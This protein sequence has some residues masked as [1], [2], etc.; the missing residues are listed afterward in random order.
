MCQHPFKEPFNDTDATAILGH[1]LLWRVGIAHG[2]VSF[3]NIML[4]IDRKRAILIDFDLAAVMKPGATSPSQSGFERT[5]TMPFMAIDVLTSWDGPG[6]LRVYPHDLEAIIWCIVWYFHERYD[7]A[8]GSMEEV[9]SKK[10][11]WVRRVLP[12]WGVGPLPRGIRAGI[13][14]R[15]L[16]SIRRI[17]FKW[18]NLLNDQ[19]GGC[20]EVDDK[21][22]NELFETGE[23][24]IDSTYMNVIFKWLPHGKDLYA[25]DWKTFAVP[26]DSI[27]K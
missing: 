20:L 6:P 21:V 22:T 14:G 13:E 4:S 2:D 5:G 3:F 18:Q 10:H 15:H 27:P 11:Q 19:C 1:K 23:P 7:W 24:D 12:G 26:V 16:E 9:C 8:I 17:L 25:W